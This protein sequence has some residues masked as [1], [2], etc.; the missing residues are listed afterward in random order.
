MRLKLGFGEHYVYCAGETPT[1]NLVE[2]VIKKAKFK[3]VPKHI[4]DMA[5]K[6]KGKAK[7]DY[8]F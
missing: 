7:W 8:Y 6:R 4:V 2:A 3:D 1:D 5:E